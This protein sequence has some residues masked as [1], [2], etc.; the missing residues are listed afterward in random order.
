MNDCEQVF[1]LKYYF[2]TCQIGKNRNVWW[3]TQLSRLWANT[4]LHVTGGDANLCDPPAGTHTHT[5]TLWTSSSLLRMCP[6]DLFCSRQALD[7]PQAPCVL[8][9]VPHAPFSLKCYPDLVKVPVTQLCPTSGLYPSRLLCPWDSPG[10]NTGV[11]GH[12]LLQGIFPTQGSNLGLPHCR[13][14]LYHLSYREWHTS[15]EQNVMKGTEGNIWDQV[16]KRLGLRSCSVLLA[17][18]EG[19][20][21]R[22]SEPL[23]TTQELRAAS[24]QAGS[25]ALSP[26]LQRAHIPNTAAWRA[27]M[28]V[29]LW[30]RPPPAGSSTQS[31]ATRLS[32]AW[33]PD[34]QIL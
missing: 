32:C 30:V 14:I 26:A 16:A 20:Q 9:L 17:H 31:Q 3:Y 12:P 6:E 13:Q 25:E 28:Q 33:I 10:R 24:S 18:M 1:S 8:G 7:G 27:C 23:Q 22:S 11:G 21:T 2:F 34:Q 15:N 5:H 4:L 29:L 19:R